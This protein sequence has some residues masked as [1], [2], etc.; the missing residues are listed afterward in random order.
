MSLLAFGL[1]PETTY[2]VRAYVT[3]GTEIYYSDQLQC[4]TM[5][6]FFGRNARFT[7][8]MLPYDEEAGWIYNH[9]YY[10]PTTPEGYNDGWGFMETEQTRLQ[11]SLFDNLY[12]GIYRYGS[13]ELK[14]AGFSLVEDSGGGDVLSFRV[15]YANSAGTTY[16]AYFCFHVTVD[17]NGML[18]V[19]DFTSDNTNNNPKNLYAN[20][21]NNGDIGTLTAYAEYL[22]RGPFFIDYILTE[23]EDETA[24]VGVMLM[25]TEAESDGE[26]FSLYGTR[27]SVPSGLIQAW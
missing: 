18:S 19:S 21:T 2:Y 16:T 9:L 25:S 14:T 4:K 10:S 27:I 11:T 8:E 3:D 13:R 1:V 24:D 7:N 17:A 23:W 6:A 20:L 5:H 15:T 12:G 22:Q 26:Y